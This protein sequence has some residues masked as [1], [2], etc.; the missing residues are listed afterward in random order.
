M[1]NYFALVPAAAVRRE[2]DGNLYAPVAYTVDREGV[3]EC[4]PRMVRANPAHV[5]NGVASVLIG[6]M[7]DAIAQRTNLPFGVMLQEAG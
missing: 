1:V 3:R 5:E 2:I 4:K 7:G 6:K